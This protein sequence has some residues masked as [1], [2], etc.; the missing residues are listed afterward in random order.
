MAPKKRARKAV[1][2]AGGDASGSGAP[3]QDVENLA[4]IQRA[5]RDVLESVLAEVR[6]FV[7]AK[8]KLYGLVSFRSF[9]LS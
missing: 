3:A 5:P 2:A 9:A 6:F 1:D 7:L 8:K 4:L